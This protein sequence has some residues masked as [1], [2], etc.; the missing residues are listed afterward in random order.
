MNRHQTMLH[1]KK[2]AIIVSIC[3]SGALGFSLPS[4]AKQNYQ[5]VSDQTTKK[6]SVSYVIGENESLV[7]AKAG[8]KE[9]LIQKA[10]NELPTYITSSK[11]VTNKNYTE[12]IRFIAAGLVRVANEEYRTKTNDQN[13]LM[14]ELTADVTIDSKALEQKISELN[15]KEKR[16][17][18]LDNLLSKDLEIQ[19]KLSLLRSLYTSD[20]KSKI[21][22]LIKESLEERNENYKRVSIQHNVNL[23]KQ[24]D[25]FQKQ[26]NADS[27][28]KEIEDRKK[29]TDE[30]TLLAELNNQIKRFAVDSFESQL[31]R[32]LELK[33]RAVK[34]YEIWFRVT[35]VK[36]SENDN[37]G[38]KYWWAE[39]EQ[40]KEKITNAFGS[41]T[42]LN[43]GCEY[44]GD[45]DNEG[46]VRSM[47]IAYQN[48]LFYAL[49]E[50]ELSKKYIKQNKKFATDLNLEQD[51]FNADR[52]GVVYYLKIT[53]GDFVTTKPFIYYENYK[54]SIN[55][56]WTAQPS[57]IRLSHKSLPLPDCSKELKINYPWIDVDKS[58]MSH[59][60]TV[61]FEIIK[62]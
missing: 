58:L 61:S 60:D 54:T 52:K 22:T 53:I 19:A 10:S 12:S 47:N 23:L 4:T 28:L 21:D 9:K 35:T 39:S 40:L 5:T 44:L 62:S 42:P 55:P 45:K 25:T 7:S 48:V 59:N 51:Y 17:E 13:S 24:A 26:Q 27:L 49:D 6:M 29:L 37:S 14:I 34:D 1:R 56:A 57:N 8:A 18:E 20:N 46:F 33:I 15:I 2:S 38:Y 41:F 30:Q 50:G 31:N 11:T 32:A 36:R 3:L 16:N 43:A